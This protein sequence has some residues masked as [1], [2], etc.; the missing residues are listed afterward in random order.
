MKN[1]KLNVVFESWSDFKSRTKKAIRE[2]TAGKAEH[3]QP[4][5]V[6]V[7]DSIAS[8]QRLMSEQ[9]YM[10]LAAIRNLKPTSMYQ[11]AKF[12]ERDFAKLKKDCETLEAAG[13]ILLEDSGDNRGTKIPKLIFDY[14][15]IEIHMPNMIYSHNLGKTAA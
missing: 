15:V 9:K 7:F 6:L 3:V 2:V 8:Y 5:D 1:K 12:V 11:L 14:N 4:Q 10:I 13:F